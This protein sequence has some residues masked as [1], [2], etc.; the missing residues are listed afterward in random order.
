ML[1]A[2]IPPSAFVAVVPVAADGPALSRLVA[3]TARPLE[4][5]DILEAGAAKVLVASAAPPAARVAVLGKPAAPGAGATSYQRA[6]YGKHLESWQAEIA[7]DERAV[8]AR[9]SATL[10]AWV[11]ALGIQQKV[12]E[13]PV[14]ADPG[15]LADE[16]AV[17]ASAMAGLGQA[18]GDIYGSRRVILVYAANLGGAPVAG[19]LTGDDVIVITSFL[20]S[21]AAASAAQVGLLNAGAAQAKVLGPEATPAQLA[22]LVTT[23][24]SQDLFTEGLSGPALFANNSAVLL[25]AAI[26]LLTPLLGPLHEPGSTAVINGYASTPGSTRRNYLLSYARAAAVAGFLEAHGVPATSLTVVGH[27]DSD[28]IAAGP[29][30]ANRRVIVVISEPAH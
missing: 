1:T 29:S 20:P 5:V 10:S 3:A 23:G 24:L 28:L 14:G 15:N 18:A 13:I 8:G 7:T 21:T 11:T 4:N 22:Q 26:R 25:P 9:T 17:A 6:A 19:E 16:C 12:N 2:H 27:G 30:A